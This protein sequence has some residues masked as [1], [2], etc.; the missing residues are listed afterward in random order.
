MGSHTGITWAG[1]GGDGGVAQGEPRARDPRA[2]ERD[3]DQGER[4]RDADLLSLRKLPEGCQQSQQGVVL[5][6]EIRVI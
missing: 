5:A 4:L 1:R 2:R 3:G 6:D